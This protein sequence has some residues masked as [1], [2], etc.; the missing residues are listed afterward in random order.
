MGRLRRLWLRL[1]AWQVSGGHGKP[2]DALGWVYQFWQKD[3]KDEVNAS[4]R[5]IGGP[6]LGPV[7]Q[8][9]T[10]NYMVRFLLE[11]SLLLV[12]G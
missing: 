3:K 9:F 12:R 4:G 10:E 5:K 11:N 8:L 7:T 1:V 6:D 2:D